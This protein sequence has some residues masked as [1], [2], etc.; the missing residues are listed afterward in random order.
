MIGAS[1]LSRF[2]SLAPCPYRKLRGG[3]A[4]SSSEPCSRFCLA[5]SKVEKEGEPERNRK[6]TE[7]VLPKHDSRELFFAIV[8]HGQDRHHIDSG[9]HRMLGMQN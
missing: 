7:A 8:V 2:T 6:D 5:G 3:I 4:Q 1:V 9:W